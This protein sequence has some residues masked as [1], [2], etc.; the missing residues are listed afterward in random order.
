VLRESAVCAPNHVGEESRGHLHCFLCQCDLPGGCL[1]PL[2]GW[3]WE[4]VGKAMANLE[5]LVQTLTDLRASHMT[6]WPYPI[7]DWIVSSVQDQKLSG[8]L[9]VRRIE[10]EE[11]SISQVTH[12][13]VQRVAQTAVVA[14]CGFSIVRRRTADLKT[15]GPRYLLFWSFSG[16]ISND[17][18]G[19]R[20]RKRVAQ[21]A[22]VAVC[23]FSIVRRRTADL[24]TGGPRY[25]LPWSFSGNL[26]NDFFGGRTQKSGLRLGLRRLD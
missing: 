12:D 19:G 5:D 20:A 14:V 15:G 4:T 17:F 10:S 16:N 3:Y 1:G 13:G 22:V 11:G 21:T 2:I 18:F 26:S 7:I 8:V 6:L 24:K 23:G 9:R 25:L